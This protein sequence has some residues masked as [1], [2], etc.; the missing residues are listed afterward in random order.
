M[1]QSAHALPGQA[2]DDLGGWPTSWL[3]PSPQ[4]PSGARHGSQGTPTASPLLPPW[5]A[6]AAPPDM[7]ATT[8]AWADP[9]P[10]A[11]TLPNRS[12]L[13]SGPWQLC[14]AILQLFALWHSRQLRCQVFPKTRTS[15]SYQLPAR[16]RLLDAA[17]LGR[18]LSTSS[19]VTRMDIII[20]E[21]TNHK[22]IDFFPNKRKLASYYYMCSLASIKQVPLF[23]GANELRCR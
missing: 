8:A 10:S 4:A 19:S 12:Q 6:T 23:C 17:V 21:L 2:R 7:G 15:C 20:P 1:G 16:Q 11:P 22:H 14:K 3:S 5:E 13:H 18:S 9:S